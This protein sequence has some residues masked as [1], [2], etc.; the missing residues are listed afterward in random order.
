M[1]CC[2][3]DKVFKSVSILLC[4]ILIFGS[5][6]GFAYAAEDDYEL[7]REAFYEELEI[8][9]N[10][11]DD[12]DSTIKVES[13]ENGET[14]TEDKTSTNRLIVSTDSNQD[15]SKNYGAI[16][17]IEG[18]NNWHIFQYRTYEEA[19]LAYEAFSQTDGVNF[20]EFDEL[21]EF[22]DFEVEPA[23]SGEYEALSWGANY[24]QS[25]TA[26]EA[27]LSSGM[28]L[29]EVVVAVIDTGVDSTHSFFN[30]DESNPRVLKGNR[31]NDNVPYEAH[32]THVAGIIVDNTLPNVK[33]RSYNF[34]Y[35]REEEVD[36]TIVTLATEIH[37]A[38]ED[39]VD[40][41]NMSLSG[42]SIRAKS[43]TVVNEI[44]NAVENNIP[45]VVA[46]GNDF[47]NASLVFPANDPNVITVAAVFENGVSAS[48]SNFGDC[49]DIAAPGVSINSTMPSDAYSN[50]NYA[51]MEG[52][53]MAA[54][55]VSAAVAM[56]KTLYPNLTPVEIKEKLISSATV[57]RGWTGLYGKGIL[58]FE[59]I[60]K[61]DRLAY[62]TINL[63][64][65]GATISSAV[66]DATVYYTTDGTAPIIGESKIY[67]SEIIDTSN[68]K[69]IKAIAYKDGY[70]P[71]YAVTKHMKFTVSDCV[72]RYKGTTELPY[73]PDSKI[74]RCYSSNPEVVTVDYSGNITGLTTG[75]ATVTVYYE[76][77]QVGT[78][79]VTVEYTWWQWL[80]RIFLLG[81]LWY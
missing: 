50:D 69:S 57:P 49:V 44:S 28:E 77:N 58:N 11:S 43:D 19:S 22:D 13:T 26:N 16:S 37:S 73:I 24:I 47:T 40:V 42:W 41:I 60:I 39:K 7:S 8:M 51:L 1:K 32:G 35:Y 66:S 65:N 74:I 38:V 2:L 59:N 52:T 9:M 68:I 10:A 30:K 71:S 34:F 64:K 15:L 36:S 45:V 6:S 53:S 5:F 79:E 61:N 20:V 63:S 25:V 29:P 23:N 48:F 18:Y 31:T 72:V 78:Y 67:S 12:Y 14:V 21:I 56:M 4:F 62:P 80:I 75:E 76:N 27:I 70:L 17:K 81:V 55:F 54:P 46:S 33:I 3:T